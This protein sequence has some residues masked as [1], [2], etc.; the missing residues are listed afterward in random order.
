MRSP[1]VSNPSDTRVP[2]PNHKEN[3]DGILKRREWCAS[4]ERDAPD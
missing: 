4:N 2:F 1:Q 3:L